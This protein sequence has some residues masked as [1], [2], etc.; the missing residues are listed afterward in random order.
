MSSDS[1]ESAAE[2]GATVAGESLMSAVA[3]SDRDDTAGRRAAATASDEDGV[4][5]DSNDKQLAASATVEMTGCNIQLLHACQ[6]AASNEVST[7]SRDN[8]I[9]LDSC[10]DKVCEPDSDR[11]CVPATNNSVCIEQIHAQCNSSPKIYSLDSQKEQND[12]DIV[13]GGVSVTGSSADSV[14]TLVSVPVVS[15]FHCQSDHSAAAA[16][17]VSS[18][19]DEDEGVVRH[20]DKT[21]DESQST[22]VHDTA[23]MISAVSEG[24]KL[25][26]RLTTRDGD[27]DPQTSSSSLSSSVPAAAA[28]KAKCELHAADVNKCLGMSDC[29]VVNNTA[30][31]RLVANDSP[32]N[33]I[34]APDI[35]TS[36]T[37]PL[38][39][40]ADLVQKVS[41]STTP[42]SDNMANKNLC[43]CLLYTSDAADE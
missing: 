6:D 26:D 31:S 28:V 1:C 18:T 20:R 22:S 3:R 29:C 2:T 7:V 27:S 35:S 43:D 36:S 25:V 24:N 9:T 32:Q 15:E 33:Y 4:S 39:S 5:I 16:A 23:A 12:V 42:R 40:L 17:A 14:N 8:D 38:K 11:L 37:Q 19:N 10:V 34:T 41:I 21:V 30:D 13:V